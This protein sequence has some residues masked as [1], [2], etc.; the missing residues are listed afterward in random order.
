MAEVWAGIFRPMRWASA[1]IGACGKAGQGTGWTVVRSGGRSEL[2]G[3]FGL[4]RLGGGWGTGKMR[5]SFSVQVGEDTVS[6]SA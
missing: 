4:G 3:R 6:V 1:R 5:R 2:V